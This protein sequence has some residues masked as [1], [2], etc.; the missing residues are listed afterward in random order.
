MNQLSLLQVLAVAAIPVLFAITLHEVAHGW[1]ARR[2]GDRTAE[3]LGRL[4]VNPLKHIDP[5]GTVIVPALALMTT[6]FLFGWAKPVPV[7]IRNLRNPRQ[8]MMLVA[9][10]GPGAN[11]LMAIFWALF[12]KLVFMSG[13][14]GMTLQFFVTMGQIGVLIN[15]ILAVFNML[16]IPPLDGGRVLSGL[17]PPRASTRLDAIEPY[18]IIIVLAFIFF[19]WRYFQPII[20]TLRDFFFAMVG[21]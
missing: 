9:A 5:I 13:M 7:S 20:F 6:G 21:L 2:F 16:P 10:A 12:T 17:L 19:G 18:G 11:I 15:V 8:H 4:T 14:Q 1:V 3:M